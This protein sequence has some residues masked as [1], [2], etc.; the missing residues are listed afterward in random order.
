MTVDSRHSRGLPPGCALL[1]TEWGIGIDIAMKLHGWSQAQAWTK[2]IIHW[3]HHGSALP[4]KDLIEAGET[5]NTE[6]WTY[7]A[8]MLVAK[9]DTPFKLGV[10]RTTRGRP[11]DQQLCSLIDY[12]KRGDVKPLLYVLSQQKVPGPAVLSHIAEMLPPSEIPCSFVIVHRFH[13]KRGPHKNYQIEFRNRIIAD[14]FAD[15]LA[16][17]GRGTYDSITMDIAKEAAVSEQTVRD[18]YDRYYGKK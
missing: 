11:R 3:L 1:D 5:P 13:K 7:F 14:H 17:L 6:I 9:S 8:N 12:L 2:V 4:L 18:A 10:R 15:R 16:A